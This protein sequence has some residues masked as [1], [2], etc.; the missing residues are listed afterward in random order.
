VGGWVKTDTE[1]TLFVCQLIPRA[2]TSPLGIGGERAGYVVVVLNRR[3]LENLIL[4][5]KDVENVEVTG[6]FLMIGVK[7]REEGG[8]NETD[9]DRGMTMLGFFIH[10]DRSDTREVN[11]R[12]IREKWEE[13]RSA[14]AKDGGAQR[15]EGQRRLSLRDLFGKQVLG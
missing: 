10:A 9:G 4:D 3:G 8:L 2:E 5:L 12:L 11:C 6:D 13:T 1:G 7:G 15:V 14:G